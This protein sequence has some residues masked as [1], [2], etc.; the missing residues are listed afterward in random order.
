MTKRYRVSEI[1][2]K[3][4]EWKVGNQNGYTTSTNAIT[5]AEKMLAKEPDKTYVIGLY[6]KIG[7]DEWDYMKTI[8]Y[9]H[10]DE[11]D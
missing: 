1:S 4:Y 7:P 6:E 10:N 8:E 2:A 3:G 9:V 5:A 11:E